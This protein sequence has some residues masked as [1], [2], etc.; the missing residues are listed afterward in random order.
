VFVERIRAGIVAFAAADAFG[1]PWEGMPPEDLRGV[2]LTALPRREDWPRGATSDDTAQLILTARVL[3]SGGE[4]LGRRFMELLAEEFPRMRGAGPTTTAAVRR[5]RDSGELG[6][7][8]GGTNGAAMRALPIGWATLGAD[9]ETRRERALSISRATHGAPGALI[10][11]GTVAAMGS[12]SLERVPLEAI[13]DRA[14]TEAETLREL[15]RAEVDLEALEA[16]A[17]GEWTPP[18]AG[19]SLDAIETVAAVLSVLR[20]VEGLAAGIEAAIGLG[21]DT[22]TVAAIVAGVLAGLGSDP[23]AE[24]PWLG[25]VQLPDASLL[26]ELASGLAEKRG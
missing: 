15:L 3:C 20:Q 10:A 16:A 4:D 25:L 9:A 8:G 1:A 14:A 19:V 18:A 21:G 7:A 11:A 17:Q 24:L 23:K 22:D 12:W 2:D 26:D 5:W 13:C 6:A